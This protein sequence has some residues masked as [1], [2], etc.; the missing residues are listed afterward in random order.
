MQNA[1]SPSRRK[2]NF[3]L[4]DKISE[5]SYS[6]SLPRNVRLAILFFIFNVH[7][8]HVGDNYTPYAIFHAADL[9]NLYV[10]ETE[11]LVAALVAR[12]FDE[13]SRSC[14]SGGTKEEEERDLDSNKAI[15]GL[16][17][18]DPKCVKNRVKVLDKHCTLL[19]TRLAEF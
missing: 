4:G 19:V 11:S 12:A 3:F 8:V 16:G 9:H 14:S 18:I 2:V 5:M 17:V 1:G 7:Q 15:E 10:S 13:G 6:F